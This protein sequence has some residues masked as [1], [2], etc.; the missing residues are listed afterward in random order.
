ML[1]HSVM[2]LDA[3]LP[4]QEAPLTTFY[5]QGNRWLECDGQ[6]RICRIISTNPADYLDESLSIG[7][8][9]RIKYE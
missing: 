8:K 2:M 1:I 6:K 9:I 3:L 7:A 4:Q 5:Q